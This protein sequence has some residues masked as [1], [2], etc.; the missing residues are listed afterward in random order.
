M[1]YV[2]FEAGN[3]AYKL[4]LNTRNIITLEKALG[5]NPLAIFGIDEKDARVPTVTE[6]VALLHAALQQYQ[7][8]ITNNEACDIFDAWLED[9]HQVTEFMAVIIEVYKA[10]GIIK[11]TAIK[12]EESEKN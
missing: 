2:D 4:R 7:H 6:M 9:G 5:T 3:K 1:L 8:G 12:D 10:S 11:D